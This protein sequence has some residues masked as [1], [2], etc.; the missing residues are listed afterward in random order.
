MRYDN[1]EAAVEKIV[2]REAALAAAVNASPSAETLANQAAAELREKRDLA[3]KRFQT[4]LDGFRG[5][6]ELLRSD[7]PVTPRVKLG[8]KQDEGLGDG[9]L[10]ASVEALNSYGKDTQLFDAMRFKTN[11]F[12]VDGTGEEHAM[13][14]QG[15]IFGMSPGDKI[16]CSGWLVI[17]QF[18]RVMGKYGPS[19]ERELKKMDELCDQ[20]SETLGLLIAKAADPDLNP[21]LA[22]RFQE[23]PPS[24]QSFTPVVE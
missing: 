1:L 17:P 20:A 12:F 7:L 10:W 18:N 24:L 21:D 9:E 3:D 14:R 6:V 5:F 22:P 15:E 13:P 4:V 16:E 11:I 8:Q 23:L 2:D 19:V